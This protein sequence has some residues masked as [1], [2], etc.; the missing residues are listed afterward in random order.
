M[1]CQDRLCGRGYDRADTEW[2]SS[3]TIVRNLISCVR[4]G[5]NFL[6]NIGPK[7]DGSLPEA[8]TRILMEVGDWLRG[9]G[10][11]VYGSELCQPWRP[12]YATFTRSGNTLFMHVHFWPGRDVSLSGLKVKVNAAHLLKGQKAIEFKQDDYRVHLT[13]LPNEAPDSPVTTIVIEC[14]AEPRQDSDPEL[15]LEK[16]RGGVNMAV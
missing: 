14:D 2:K 6:L 15:R 12:S 10:E 1:F 5:G 7:G 4:D 16:P 13:G 3:R 11:S 9:S 8:S